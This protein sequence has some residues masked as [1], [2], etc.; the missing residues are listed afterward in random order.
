[1]YVGSVG[2]RGG[3]HGA[4]KDGGGSS[5]G[6]GG[7]SRNSSSAGSSQGN[8]PASDQHTHAQEAHT[9]SIFQGPPSLPTYH[10]P[11][12][13]LPF[14]H[15]LYSP[16]AS[17][18]KL[19]TP[20]TR[21]SGYSF[22]GHL[23]ED[24]S[25]EPA[26]TV[27]EA[28]QPTKEEPSEKAPIFKVTTAPQEAFGRSIR[29]EAGTVIHSSSNIKLKPA[30]GFTVVSEPKEA[31]G[32]SSRTKEATIH[33]SADFKIKPA[34]ELKVVKEKAMRSGIFEKGAKLFREKEKEAEH[35]GEIITQQE[36][37]EK[38]KVGSK[39]ITLTNAAT[40]VEEYLQ[41]AE[42]LK[43][44]VP[45]SKAHKQHQEKGQAL[46][47]Q[48]EQLKQK[49]ERSYQAIQRSYLV[50]NS[51]IGNQMI[52]ERLNQKEADLEALEATRTKLGSAL[53]LSPQAPRKHGFTL[54]PR[55]LTAKPEAT[56]QATIQSPKEG[57]REKSKTFKVVS[58]SRGAPKGTIRAKTATIHSS[59][60][61]KLKPASGFKVVT[62]KAAHGGFSG[63][64]EVGGSL[65]LSPCFDKRKAKHGDAWEVGQEINF[66][67]QEEIKHEHETV[68][69]QVQE[70]E[71]K[72]VKKAENIS[73]AAQEAVNLITEKYGDIKPE[74]NISVNEAFK[75]LTG[76]TELEKKVADEMVD[77][78]ETSEDWEEIPMSEAQELANKGEF[79]VAG[80]QAGPDE[81]MGHVVVIVPGEEEPSTEW[82][83]KVPM[84]MDTGKGR[85]WSSRK[86]SYSWRKERKKD[87]KFF[88]YIGPSEK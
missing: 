1:M 17:L 43:N 83:C 65:R 9:H 12:E 68:I 73:S 46:S 28:V 41:E 49:E 48:V 7:S 69:Q 50:D 16:P 6:D 10:L 55:G 20:S 63:G 31:P 35:V 42:R 79:V 22:V 80:A 64:V 62:E 86:V 75:Q 30:T 51:D 78:W 53:E 59:A 61:L 39:H 34:P 58:E 70:V 67:G 36:A 44:Q 4:S 40:A 81:N 45:T 57:H 32:G 15:P 13:D 29:A 84:A 25:T 5:G 18:G 88:R 56:I 76:S 3:G 54:T 8:S 19:T 72:K 87:V 85:R 82:N 38:E 2:L 21:S 11:T 27:K 47:K 14:H 24:I 37:G 60:D 33:G 23:G 74:C 66:L 26:A 71:T 52:Q 77:H